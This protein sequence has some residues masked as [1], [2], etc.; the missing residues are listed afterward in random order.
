MQVNNSN[1]SYWCYDGESQYSSGATQEPTLNR[2]G[3]DQHTWERFPYRMVKIEK[4]CLMQWF[5]IRGWFCFLGDIWQSLEIFLVVTGG[6]GNGGRECQWPIGR[7]QGCCKTPYNTQDSL[8]QH[9]STLVPYAQSAEIG[10]LWCDG[11][12]FSYLRSSHHRIFLKSF[13]S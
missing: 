5:S 3:Y 12:W 7:G 11:T 13:S 6:C 9:K 1:M 10:K 8:P 4:E 2:L